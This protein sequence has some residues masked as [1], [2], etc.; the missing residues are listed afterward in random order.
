M[1]RCLRL[2]GP[3]MM[4]AGL[5]QASPTDTFMV[6]ATITPGCL[7]NNSIPADGAQLGTLGSL[8]FGTT[9]AL[10]QET[11]SASLIASGTFTLSC[12]PGIALNMRIDGGLQ[13]TT[14]RQLK[15]E[16]GSE[17]LAYQLY[18][19]AASVN[20]IDIDQPI[21]IDTT[22]APDDIPLPVW[23]QVTLPGNLPAGNYHD[24]LVLTLEW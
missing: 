9:S 20:P 3:M 14:E 2:I 7:V 1:A 10:S 18:Q 23:G 15:R 4:V 22:T 17:T 19:D 11:R 6:S 12:T 8:A 21:A 24:E 13:P 16:D 5:A